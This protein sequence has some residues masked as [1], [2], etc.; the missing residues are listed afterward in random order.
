MPPLWTLVYPRL[1]TH[2]DRSTTKPVAGSL[3][4]RARPAV[5]PRPS[6]HSPIARCPA[7]GPAGGEHDRGEFTTDRAP[8]GFLLEHREH[9]AAGDRAGWPLR[10]RRR[11]SDPLAGGQLV[12]HA[13]PQAAG[14]RGARTCV[15]TVVRAGWGGALR[16]Y[17]WGGILGPLSAYR[18]L[19]RFLL[20]VNF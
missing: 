12:Q 2:P 11:A 13:A 3:S 14:Q 7:P 17:R 6:L 4:A 5:S 10:G 20:G 1:R 19:S 18:L 9:P 8:V 15:A 16:A